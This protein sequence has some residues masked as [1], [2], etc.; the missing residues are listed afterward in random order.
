MSDSKCDIAVIGLGAIG[1]ATLMHLAKSGAHVIG[2][3][4]YSPPHNKGS[5]HGEIRITRLSI[6]E[7]AEY[8]PLV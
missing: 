3:D 8:I 7:G 5:S 2:I 6:G 1:A 4:Q